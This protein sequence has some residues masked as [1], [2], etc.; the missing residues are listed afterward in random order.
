MDVITSASFPSTFAYLCL[1]PTILR[2]AMTSLSTS[3][4]LWYCRKKPPECDAQRACFDADCADDYSGVT[5]VGS[6]SG[7]GSGVGVSP[8]SGD[9]V[10]SGVGVSPPLVLPPLVFPPLM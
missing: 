6:G 5:G 1:S 7:S 2:R 4:R 3:S 8:P 9:G 10:G